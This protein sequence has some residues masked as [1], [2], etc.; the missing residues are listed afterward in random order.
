MH[1]AI[2]K[3]EQYGHN[4]AVLLETPEALDAWAEANREKTFRVF[5]VQEM[6][7]NKKVTFSLKPNTRSGR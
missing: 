3:H 1:I 4:H 7:V 5:Q 2:Y 6:E